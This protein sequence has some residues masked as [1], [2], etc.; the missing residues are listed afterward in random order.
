[1]GIQCLPYMA[2]EV[3]NTTQISA[4]NSLPKPNSESSAFEYTFSITPL[5]RKIKSPVR[6]SA[7]CFALLLYPS[8]SNWTSVHLIPF[9]TE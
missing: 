3:K 1:M 2:G 7:D 9:L 6:E 8:P 4:V 5:S